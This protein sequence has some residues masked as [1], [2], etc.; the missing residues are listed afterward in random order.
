MAEQLWKNAV[1]T[2]GLTPEEATLSMMELTN[3]AQEDKQQALTNNE[4]NTLW[5]AWSDWQAELGGES[6]PIS[7]SHPT[8]EAKEDHATEAQD[9]LE[10]EN[11]LFTSGKNF[12]MTSHAYIYIYM[13]V[14]S[15]RL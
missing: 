3:M 15:A 14:V 7:V 13:C 10:E 5:L 2:S 11:I 6:S 4:K 9:T 12:H 1:E 8:V